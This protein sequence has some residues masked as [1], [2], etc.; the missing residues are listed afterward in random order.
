MRDLSWS[1]AVGGAL[2]RGAWPA[3]AAQSAPAKGN[4]KVPL[5]SPDFYP[6][7]THPVGWRGDGTGQFPGATPPT[8][9]SRGEKGERK[10]ILWEAKLPC[11]SWAT[12]IVVGDKVFT[13]PEDPAVVFVEAYPGVRLRAREDLVAD[14]DPNRTT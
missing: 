7:P 5:G 8:T 2:V 4:D 13:H 6:S 11:Y 12:P 3:W 14:H 10:N 1:V 9:W